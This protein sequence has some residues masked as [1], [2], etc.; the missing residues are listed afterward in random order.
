[1]DE[2]RK[3]NE[4][5]AYDYLHNNPSPTD[6]NLTRLFSELGYDIANLSTGSLISFTYN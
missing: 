1:M 6:A 2:V 4:G 3:A 5:R